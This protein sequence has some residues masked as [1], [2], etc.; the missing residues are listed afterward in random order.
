[1][2]KTACGVLGVND[3]VKDVLFD[4]NTSFNRQR[5]FAV[6]NAVNFED[7][8]AKLLGNESLPWRRCF[9]VLCRIAGAT[10]KKVVEMWI[11]AAKASVAPVVAGG[12][13]AAPYNRWFNFYTE[14]MFGNHRPQDPA[15]ERF[16]AQC[17]ASVCVAAVEVHGGLGTDVNFADQFYEFVTAGSRVWTQIYLNSGQRAAVPFNSWQEAFASFAAT[18][19]SKGFTLNDLVYAPLPLEEDEEDDEI[20]LLSYR[21]ISHLILKQCSTSLQETTEAP[22]PFVVWLLGQDDFDPTS[23]DPATQWCALFTTANNVAIDFSQQSFLAQLRHPK[24]PFKFVNNDVLQPPTGN[25]FHSLVTNAVFPDDD[26]AVEIRAWEQVAICC[27]ELNKRAGEQ[28]KSMLQN[29]D[30][31]KKTPLDVFKINWGSWLQQSKGRGLSSRISTVFNSFL[32]NLTPSPISA[33]DTV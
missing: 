23:L 8:V 32:T 6:S 20:A 16:V 13:A 15:S 3:R 25:L 7:Q 9:L 26:F 24:A 14:I 10:E 29:L 30:A 33:M 21:R 18:T 19:R 28:A 22:H 12:E 5:F 11:Q 31:E 2:Y 4:A 17:A 27:T 1:V